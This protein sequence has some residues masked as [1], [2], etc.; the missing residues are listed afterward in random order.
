MITKLTLNLGCGNDTR[1]VIR[2]DLS[3]NRRGVNLIADAHHLPLRNK[4]VDSVLCKSMLEHVWSPFMVISEMKR[5]TKGF[6]VLS[7][8]N[9]MHLRRIIETIK[10][11]FYQISPNTRHLQIWDSKA[12]RHLANMTSLTVESITW[13][14]NLLFSRTMIVVLRSGL[15]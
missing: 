1:G 12:I 2:I 6:I 8:P 15:K 10:N 14:P 9:V 11:P 13:N 3:S 7:I 4:I 5:V